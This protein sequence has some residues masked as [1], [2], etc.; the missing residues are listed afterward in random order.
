MLAA[1]FIF[2][3]HMTSLLHA[4]ISNLSMSILYICYPHF[5]SFI[6][7]EPLAEE[8]VYAEPEP[9]VQ[10]PDEE[11]VAQQPHEE[12]WYEEPQPVHDYAQE[13]TGELTSNPI[14]QG[15][16]LKHSPMQIES[17]NSV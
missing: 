12:Q 9:I 7:I 10:E 15:R 11:L 3:H 2:S 1:L 14:E 4:R 6:H 16:H 5:A 8:A 13:A 17:H